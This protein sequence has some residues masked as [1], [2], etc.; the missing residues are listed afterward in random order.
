MVHSLNKW[1]PFNRCKKC[2]PVLPLCHAWHEPSKSPLKDIWCIWG[3]WEV[4]EIWARGI[5]EKTVLAPQPGICKVLSHF[6]NCIKTH[7]PK[8]SLLIRLEIPPRCC[9][10]VSH[11][12]WNLPKEEKHTPFMSMQIWRR[13]EGK[14]EDE[15]ERAEQGEGWRKT[16][17][18]I[19]AQKFWLVLHSCNREKM[20]DTRFPSGS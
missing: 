14:E 6:N 7:P 5:N 10:L 18:G 19:K 12:D 17:S 3:N 4:S 2:P 1:L 9:T 13:K 16:E 20:V 15:E 8:N 11:L